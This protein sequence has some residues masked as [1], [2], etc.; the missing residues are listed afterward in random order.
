MEGE[1]SSFSSSVVA[2]SE[3]VRGAQPAEQPVIVRQR[4]SNRLVTR[5]SH[6]FKGFIF[7]ILVIL[8]PFIFF[9]SV[10]K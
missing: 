7:V 8:F 5:T 6:L 2:A 9:F 4:K 1:I 3:A 10:Y